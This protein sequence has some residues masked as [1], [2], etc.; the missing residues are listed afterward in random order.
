MLGS[1]PKAYMSKK[2][3]LGADYIRTHSAWHLAGDMKNYGKVNGVNTRLPRYYR[4]RIFNEIQK[5]DLAF[6]SLMLAADARAKE[7]DRL[8]E[9]HPDPYRHYVERIQFM[10]DAVT[11]KLND[12]NTF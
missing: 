4:D 3:G 5:A 2:P 1:R 11:N 10:H 6:Q 7:L 9:L 8:C 12:L